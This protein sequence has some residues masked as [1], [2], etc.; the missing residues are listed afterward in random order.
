MQVARVE[1][2]R[3]DAGLLGGVDERAP[4]GVRVR[5]G[6]SAGAVMEV[7][8]LADGASRRPAPSPH[9][10]PAR[11]RGS[12]RDRVARPRR[13]S[14][15]AR[16]RTSRCRAGCGRGAPAGR[17]WTFAESRNGQPV[18][19]RRVT[20]RGRDAALDRGD[21]TVGVDRHACLGTLAAEP[22]ELAPVAAHE[23]NSTILRAR[24]TKASR[25]AL[26]LLPGAEGPGVADAVH[27]QR[28]VE[29]VEL[30]L[31]RAGRQPRRVSSCSTPSRSR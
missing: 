12:C 9:R 31:E 28:A 15:R 26:E 8:E 30:V 1:R 13:T 6:R 24:S 22:G 20:G 25:E 2:R 7:V 19:S 18:E 29:V 16:S 5:V 17:W 23:P 3:S 21:H 11:G 10:W 4:H 14:A 27:E